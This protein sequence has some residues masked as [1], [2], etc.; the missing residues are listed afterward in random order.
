[1]AT[2][3]HKNLGRALLWGFLVLWVWGLQWTSGGPLGFLGSCSGGGWAPAAQPSCGAAA[4]GA[5]GA[6][7]FVRGV[8]SRDPG[9]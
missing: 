4:A 8:R 3:R 9:A 1:M 5:P 6:S 7:V 2:D